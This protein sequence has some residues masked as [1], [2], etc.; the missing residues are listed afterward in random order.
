MYSTFKASLFV[1]FII[2]SIIGCAKQEQVEKIQEGGAEVIINHNEPYRVKGQPAS[3]YL[4]KEISIDMERDEIAEIG[5]PD[6][7]G[8]EADSKG[9]IYFFI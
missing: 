6:V 7:R 8:I 5:L 1:V 3:L 9:N 2:F 4:E